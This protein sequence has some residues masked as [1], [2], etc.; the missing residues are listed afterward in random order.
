M[1]SGGV[2]GA[3]LLLLLMEGVVGK[4]V[5]VIVVGFVSGMV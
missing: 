3:R 4:V 5:E 2:G 1:G